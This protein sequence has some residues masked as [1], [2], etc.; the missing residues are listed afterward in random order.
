MNI[1]IHIG[2]PKT[3][4][5][6]LQETL[7]KDENYG[8]YA[9]HDGNSKTVRD[10]K[11]MALPFYETMPFDFDAEAVR[12]YIDR[13]CPLEEE[14]CAVISNERLSG[15]AF[16]GGY[17]SVD[18]AKR[19]YSVFPNARIFMMIREQFDIII[20]QYFQKLKKGLGQSFQRYV[21][22]KV[23]DGRPSFMIDHYKYDRLIE[24]YQQLFGKDK[25]L[26]YPFEAL[27][28]DPFRLV[29]TLTRFCDLSLD[30]NPE[31]NEKYKNQYN[32]HSNY[33]AASATRLLGP[34]FLSHAVNGYSPYA[35]PISE[36]KGMAGLRVLRKSLGYFIPR[37]WDNN[38][39]KRQHEFLS[40]HFG[41]DYFAESN[42]K[43]EDLTGLNLK[44]LGYQ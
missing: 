4:S 38:L 6:W 21:G 20:S 26:I 17:D 33:F 35:L 31:L 10:V 36:S 39:L 30:F 8:F 24:L 43:T 15:G 12:T 22:K 40:T 44:D 9:L 42:R 2:Y 16:F 11:R 34:L 7:F 3:A 14:K 13:N 18:I 32:K 28:A 19:L 25:V 1:L 37:S 23:H 29:N 27:K 5:S 41:P